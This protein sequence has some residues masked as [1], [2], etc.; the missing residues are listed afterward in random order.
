MVTN[1]LPARFKHAGVLYQNKFIIHSGNDGYSNQ[2]TLFS[3]EL[4]LL[5]PDWRFNNKFCNIFFK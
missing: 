4:K 5:A 3:L 2:D 1:K